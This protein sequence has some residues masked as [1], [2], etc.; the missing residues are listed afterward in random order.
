MDMVILARRYIEDHPEALAFHSTAEYEYNKI[1]N[2]SKHTSSEEYRRGWPEDRSRRG[3]VSS[4]GHA[5]RDGRRMIA[6]VMGCDR[7]SKRAQ[8]AQALL[9]YGFKNFQLWRLSRREPLSVR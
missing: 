4:P 1:G 2:T 5:K 6:V 9:E 7:M 8:E 3:Q